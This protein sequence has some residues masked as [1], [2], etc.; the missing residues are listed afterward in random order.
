MTNQI[1]IIT[2]LIGHGSDYQL[3]PIVTHSNP[4][5]NVN[6]A[7]LLNS[8]IKMFL[9]DSATQT[10][11]RLPSSLVNLRPEAATKANLLS[12]DQICVRNLIN[13]ASPNVISISQSASSTGIINSMSTNIKGSFIVLSDNVALQKHSIKQMNSECHYGVSIR[14]IEQFEGNDDADVSYFVPGSIDR[15]FVMLA[16]QA[17]HSRDLYSQS[18]TSF[19]P[20]VITHLSIPKT[21]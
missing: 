7:N 12:R 17:V 9:V 15:S 20:S 4:I 16:S 6:I 3:V 11:F 21:N 19:D 13:E 14:E 1:I 18:F 8:S 2:N 10:K 5:I